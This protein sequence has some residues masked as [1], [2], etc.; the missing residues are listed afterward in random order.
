MSA[1]VGARYFVMLPASYSVRHNGCVTP[2]APDGLMVSSRKPS[3]RG[4]QAPVSPKAGASVMPVSMAPRRKLI[5]FDDETL[6]AV[7][8]LSRDTGKTLQQL[9][10]EAFTDLLAKHHRPRTL[11]DALKQSS[12]RT[13]A[14]ENRKRGNS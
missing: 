12:Q 10:D 2:L 9:A 3:L 8:L 13:P 14:N 11:K 4:T 6:Q 5:G 7:E 1:S